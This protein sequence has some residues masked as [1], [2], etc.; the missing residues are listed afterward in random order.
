MMQWVK[1]DCIFEISRKR[2][3]RLKCKTT[4]GTLNVEDLWIMTSRTF[5]RYTWRESVSSGRWS[6]TTYTF[7]KKPPAFLRDTH[8]G[9]RSIADT[10]EQQHI[11][12]QK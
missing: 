3:I 5:K 9:K 10:E 2:G 6:K 12:S 7:W 1:I 8:E 4:L 11:P